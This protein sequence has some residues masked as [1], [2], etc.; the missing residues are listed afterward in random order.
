MCRPPPVR[1]RERSRF[2]RHPIRPAAQIAI[3]TCREHAR[4]QNAP[5]RILFCCFSA[6]DLAVYEELLAADGD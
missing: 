4:T 1:R 5:T 3:R 6:E 2:P